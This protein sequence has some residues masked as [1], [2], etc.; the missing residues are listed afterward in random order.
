MSRLGAAGAVLPLITDGQAEVLY[1]ILS[2]VDASLSS[3][4]NKNELKL[5]FPQTLELIII[6]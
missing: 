5:L 2:Y 1:L 3:T 4:L 6:L